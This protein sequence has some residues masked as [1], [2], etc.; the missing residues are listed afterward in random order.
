M[1]NFILKFLFVVLVGEILTLL[2]M[3]SGKREEKVLAEMDSTSSTSL[4]TS[5]LATSTPKSTITPTP[6]ITPSPSPTPTPLDS[7]FGTSNGA[8]S[9]PTPVST[10]VATPVPLFTSE[11]INGFIDQYSAV[12]GTDP[13]VIRR[14]AICE[15]GF[16][17]YATNYVYSGLFQFGPITW[18]NLRSKMGMD[19]NPYLRN[20]ALEAVRTASYAVSLGEIKIWPNCQP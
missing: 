15:S 13:N 17:Q 11:Q 5:P 6:T 18:Q 10:P 8:S 16:N 2:I 20:N 7:P 1:K 3:N 9:T 12:Y 19:P 14:L 4:T